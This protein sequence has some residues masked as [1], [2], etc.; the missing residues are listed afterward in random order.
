[1]PLNGAT[2]RYSLSPTT[3]SIRDAVPVAEDRG[4]SLGDRAQ[5]LRLRLRRAADGNMSCVT[6]CGGPSSD[7]SI[8]GTPFWSTSW[9]LSAAGSRNLI[10]PCQTP[11]EG[12]TGR[13]AGAREL[14]IA[15]MSVPTGLSSPHAGIELAHVRAEIG[16]SMKRWKTGSA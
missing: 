12:R 9:C 3:P 15:W 8:R 16:C 5:R 11:V 1:M 13:A 4:G 2:R 14:R 7:S 10:V 6:G